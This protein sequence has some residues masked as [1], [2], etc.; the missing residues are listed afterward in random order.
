MR[1]LLPKA[2]KID[3]PRPTKDLKDSDLVRQIVD[4]ANKVAFRE[5]CARYVDG[6]YRLVAARLASEHDAEDLVQEIFLAMYK[7]L[8]NFRR[9]AQFSTWLYQIAQNHIGQFYRRKSR[10]PQLQPMPAADML[11]DP[12]ESP[13]A[14]LSRGEEVTCLRR[15][16]QELPDIY[17]EAFLLRTAEGFSYREIAEILGCAPGTVDSRISR[18]RTLLAEKLREA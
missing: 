7:A 6:I 1:T 13:A 18:A 11:V 16:I 12:A 4:E 17:R 15:A 5:L 8:P 2:N 9:E 3:R 10:R 14:K